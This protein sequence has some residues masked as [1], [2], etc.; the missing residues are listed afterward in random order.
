MESWCRRKLRGSNHMQLTCERQWTQFTGSSMEKMT[1]AL[2]I[3]WRTLPLS[4][5][6]KVLNLIGHV[7]LG[8]AISDTHPEAGSIG[9]SVGIAGTAFGNLNARPISKTHIECY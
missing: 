7:S 3:T 9:R 8:M 5:M 6:Y 2:P 4:F 1:C